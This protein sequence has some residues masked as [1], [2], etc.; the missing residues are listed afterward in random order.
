MRK[1][2]FLLIGAMTLLAFTILTTAPCEGCVT[3]IHPDGTYTVDTSG[4]YND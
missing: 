3:E 2:T 1:G 4:C